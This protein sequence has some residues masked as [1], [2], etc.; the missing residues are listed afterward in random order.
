MNLTRCLPSLYIVAINGIAKL[1]A[2]KRESME[3]S[4]LFAE[5]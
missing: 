2:F 5:H 3:R 4:L 1:S